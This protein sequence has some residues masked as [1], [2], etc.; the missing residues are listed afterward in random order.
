MEISNWDETT[1]EGDDTETAEALGYSRVFH[2]VDPALG[3]VE[4]E[5]IEWDEESEE[6]LEMGKVANAARSSFL[7]HNPFLLRRASM[8]T[9]EGEGM[10]V[11]QWDESAEEEYHMEIEHV[12]RHSRSH[13]LESIDFL[14]LDEDELDLPVWGSESFDETRSSERS[15]IKDMY[16]SGSLRRNV[17]ENE[18]VN[19]LMEQ[20]ILNKSAPEGSISDRLTERNDDNFDAWALEECSNHHDTGVPFLILGTSAADKDSCPHVLS[21]PLMESLLSA[22]PFSNSSD[23]FWMKYSLIRDGASMHTFLQRARGVQNSILA[24]ETVD[25]EVFG[26]FTTDPWRKTWSYF[27]R[28]ESLLWKL[29]N[30]RNKRYS[31]TIE[32]AWMESDINVYPYTGNNDCIQICNTQHIAV[33]GGAPHD[34]DSKEEKEGISE[35]EWGYGLCIQKDMIHGT[36]SPCVTFDSPSLSRIHADGS[37]FE[38]INLELW[39]LTPCISEED[40]EKLEM[41]MLLLEEN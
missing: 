29:K 15:K 28:G 32:A 36:T 7:D 39:S 1:E 10:E 37:I 35:H 23:N 8:N 3:N 24:I 19:F 27:G 4:K 26:A 31:S 2:F 33:G 13:S 14:D 38:I 9:Y 21:P 22:V 12:R 40:A 16:L 30:S 17:S 25:G 41:H 11:A 6:E 18:L 34:A 5:D 20:K